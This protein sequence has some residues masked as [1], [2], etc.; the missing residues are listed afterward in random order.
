MKIKLRDKLKLFLSTV[1]FWVIASLLYHILR[2]IGIGG[3]F[4]VEI[5]APL[6]K[7]EGFRIAFF[8]G[9][10]TGI[11][12]GAL[13][14][15]FENSWLVRK[16]LGLRL[17][18]KTVA[19]T[20]LI[21]LVMTIGINY[22]NFVIGNDNTMSRSQIFESGAIFSVG[23]FFI[24]SSSFYSFLRLVNE[25]FG[26]GILWDMILGKYR[27]PRVEKKIFMFMDLKS[28]TT[29]AEKMGYL[30]YSALIQQCFYD[31]NEIVQKYEGQIYQ[32]VGDEAV[33]CWDYTKGLQESICID[34][35][36]AF[37]EKLQSRK[38]F[39]EE[40]FG[41]MPE[42]KAGLHGGE[43]VVTE[44]GVIKKEIAYHGDVINTTARIQEQCNIYNEPLLISSDLIQDLHVQEKY[45]PIL[46]G[47][48][49]L[50]GKEA[51]VHL[52]SVKAIS[53]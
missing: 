31:L 4:G 23:T 13:E 18:I 19:Y 44:V 21:G 26:P 41:M 8:I 20:F 39:Y 33:I 48:V 9:L 42:F 14:I 11:F 1:L 15:L 43:L 51:K 34:C 49:L 45:K 53:I 30:S 35:F 38:D 29:Y 12:Y 17:L 5:V 6:S 50:K 16:S 36:F 7:L 25:K 28:S 40:K 47:E 3:E 32:Y 46:I 27:N 10:V 24:L 2:R 52:H 22:V 37:Q